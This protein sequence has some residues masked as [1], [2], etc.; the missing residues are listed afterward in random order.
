MEGLKLASPLLFKGSSA[1]SG[2]STCILVM[3]L[4]TGCGSG[5][6][7]MPAVPASPVSNADW[8]LVGNTGMT[9]N[10]EILSDNNG[11]LYASSNDGSGFARSI[12]HGVTWSPLNG[13]ASTGCHWALGLNDLGEV[14]STS[15]VN[16]NK[17]CN[18][19]VMERLK[20][21][22]STWSESP[23][24]PGNNL[25]FGISFTVA[26]NGYLIAA[27]SGLLGFSTDHGTTWTAPQT[28]PPTQG[29]GACGERIKLATQTGVVSVTLADC[30][31]YFSTDNGNN[32]SVYPQGFPPGVTF[33][34]NGNL[35]LPDGTL[36]DTWQGGVRTFC[37]G[38]QVPPN[39]AWSKCSSG[40]TV[41]HQIILVAAR[42]GTKL[43]GHQGTCGVWSSPFPNIKWSPDNNGLTFIQGQP[44]NC[45][46]PGLFGIT[47]DPTTGYTFM[48]VSSNPGSGKDGDV[49]RTTNP[50]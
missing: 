35:T 42:S 37:Y 31:P 19:H 4:V 8:V 2:L 12:D 10:L 38:P 24:P 21:N 33:N 1:V 16:P 17:G 15:L 45:G 27:G 14:V 41:P 9:G 44:N 50:Q 30:A 18:A 20:G 23:P 26:P 48:L 25:T 7:S 32:W 13:G 11:N 49:W 47:T 34:D 39:G 28:V 22:G 29:S 40:Q 3:A 6:T 36:L 46:Y 5:S 43:V